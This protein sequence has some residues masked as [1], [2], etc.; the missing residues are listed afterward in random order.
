MAELSN[1]FVADPELVTE[2]QTRS[3]PVSLTARPI[4][5]RQGEK[6]T[7]VYLVKDGEVLLTSQGDDTFTIRAG[8]GSLLGIPAVIGSKPYSLTAEAMAG[9]QVEV[10]TAD[11]FVHLMQANPA[12]AFQVLQILASEVRMARAVLAHA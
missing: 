8:A 11:E 3:A 6:P 7:A 1:A 4:L 10:V 9:A 2:L 5:F 12:L